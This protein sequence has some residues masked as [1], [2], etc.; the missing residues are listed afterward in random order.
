MSPRP[1][2]EGA[3]LQ[4]KMLTG[5]VASAAYGYFPGAGLARSS[6]LQLRSRPALLTAPTD[7]PVAADGSTDAPVEPPVDPA[8]TEASVKP[9]CSKQA[10][11]NREISQAE[12]SEEVLALVAENAADLNAVNVA[13]ALHHGQSAVFAR[14]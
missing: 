6:A 9:V 8:D 11:L 7:A 14:P 5:L 13:T 10:E 4:T 2:T 3:T 1:S 12:S